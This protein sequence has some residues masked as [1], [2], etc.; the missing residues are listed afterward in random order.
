MPTPPLP[1]TFQIQHQNLNLRS[2]PAGS[3]L[4]HATNCLGKWGAGFAKELRAIYPGAYL[5]YRNFCSSRSRDLAGRC[6]IIP[7]QG[8]DYSSEE[9]GGAGVSVVCL[10]TSYGYGRRGRG[11]GRGTTTGAA[12]PG[13]DARGLILA[14]T[15]RALEEFRAQVLCGESGAI[16]STST[17]TTTAAAA[18]AAADEESNNNREEPGSD[19]ASGPVSGKASPNT[20]KQ[21][22]QKSQD[23]AAVP[24]A[25]IYSPKFNSGLFGVPWAETER[26]IREVFGGCEDKGIGITWTVLTL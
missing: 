6:L 5:R 9:E 16:S 22:K 26:Q 7:P 14:Q 18:A 13:R 3:Y 21:K 24:Q 17:T 1:A 23:P 11:R 2:L 10:F 12:K 15:A 19:P 20:P 8:S 25:T 4:V